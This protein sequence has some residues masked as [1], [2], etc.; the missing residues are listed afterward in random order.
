MSRKSTRRPFTSA[1]HT[2]GFLPTRT[3]HCGSNGQ[4]P[5]SFSI[6]RAL[7]WT[8][9][10]P[11]AATRSGRLPQFGTS[12]RHRSATLQEWSKPTAREGACVWGAYR[13]QIRHRYFAVFLH[14]HVRDG[15]RDCCREVPYLRRRASRT[16][17]RREASAAGAAAEFLV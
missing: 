11:G 6:T 1:I 13:V 14:V 2:S 7:A 3:D 15:D 5:E 10:S 9:L 8:V 16:R 12:R 17:P 4:G